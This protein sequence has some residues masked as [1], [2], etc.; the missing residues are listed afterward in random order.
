[1]D[2]LRVRHIFITILVVIVTAYSFV[3][4]FSRGNMPRKPYI[5]PS[6]IAFPFLFTER[7]TTPQQPLDLP[8]LKHD[9]A[10]SLAPLSAFAYIGIYTAPDGQ[11]HVLT[12]KGTS[13]EHL[14]ASITKLMTGLVASE[15]FEHSQEITIGK[16]AILQEGSSGKFLGGEKFS[17][18]TLLRM[19]FIESNNDAA[20]ALALAYG[21]ELFIRRMNEKARA[22]GLEHTWYGNPTGLDPDSETPANH[23]SARDISRLL[24]HLYTSQPRLF[25]ILGE[26]SYSVRDILSGKFYTA[27]TTDQLLD[28]ATLPLHILGGKT[29][30]TT[31][32]KK[33]LAVIT[34]SPNGKGF[35]VFVV[36]YS[37]DNFTDMKNLIEWASSSFDW[38]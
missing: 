4:L 12:E 31:L 22:L 1:M 14:T 27:T 16:E 25:A 23:S 29:G 9:A 15:I 3:V 35:L 24:A 37:D 33:N 7:T 30:T 13:D 34:T 10:A 18:D 26:K 28:D 17:V 19:L 5:T 20:E 8:T 38:H 2:S 6:A 21:R 32:A 11:E 36:L